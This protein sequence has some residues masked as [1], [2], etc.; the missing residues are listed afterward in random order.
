LN[1]IYSCTGT[2]V[3]GCTNL[4]AFNY[5]S[6]ATIDDSTCVPIIEGCLDGHYLEYNSN[7]N[8]H[9][10]NSCITWKINGCT[11]PI[12]VEYNES[13]NFDDGSC[14]VLA[15]ILGCTDLNAN[16]NIDLILKAK[17]LGI[18]D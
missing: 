16:N 17:E 5:N 18:I 6:L 7:A 3:L 9:D 1:Y 12:Y 8:T 14:T 10:Q 2:A 4:T 11:D 13:A 15:D